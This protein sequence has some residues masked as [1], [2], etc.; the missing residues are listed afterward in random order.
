MVLTWDLHPSFVFSKHSMPPLCESDCYIYIPHSI[1]LAY[2]QDAREGTRYKHSLP[3]LCESG[4][5]LPL[6]NTACRRC[7]N[8]AREHESRYCHVYSMAR[9][10]LQVTTPIR[11]RSC[12]SVTFGTTACIMHKREELRGECSGMVMTHMYMSSEASLRYVPWRSIIK[13][14]LL[15]INQLRTNG[16]TALRVAPEASVAHIA[17]VFQYEDHYLYFVVLTLS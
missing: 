13:Y 12:T 3:P 4:N 6:T 1:A 17:K 8:L 10:P 9:A 16:N 11:D 7:A 15:V 14:L 2:T 5:S